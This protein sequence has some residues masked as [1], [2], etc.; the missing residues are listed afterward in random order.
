MITSMNVWLL[1]HKFVHK[2]YPF[3]KADSPGRTDFENM[4][5][6]IKSENPLTVLIAGDFNG[7]YQQW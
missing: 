7:H 2:K 1:N 5:N 3:N 4:C 6:R